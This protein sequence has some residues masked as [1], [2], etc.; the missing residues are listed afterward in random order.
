[1]SL[2]GVTQLSKLTL[3]YCRIGGSSAGMR[4][5]MRESLIE[6]CTAHP[7]VAVT[8]ELKTGRHP[9]LIASY[10]N[11]TEKVVGV[12]NLSPIEIEKHMTLLRSSIGRKTTGKNSDRLNSPVV[13]TKPSIQGVWTDD[14]GAILM[15]TK[16]DVE[17]VDL[18][19]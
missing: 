16:F 17:H 6:W 9:A 1:M 19:Q 2:R 15:A 4:E 13:S 11:G 5:H 3:R 12:K 8:T 18:E 10:L 14:V 7:T